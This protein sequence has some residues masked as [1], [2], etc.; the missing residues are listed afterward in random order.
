VIS[1]RAPATVRSPFRGGPPTDAH[2]AALEQL[3]DPGARE[4]ERSGEP[5]V[6]PHPGGIRRNLEAPARGAHS[7]S[8]SAT[9]LRGLEPLGRLLSQEAVRDAGED[10]VG[11]GVDREQRRGVG[12]QHLLPELVRRPGIEGRPAGEHLVEDDAQGVE[13][14]AGVETFTEDLLRRHVAEGTDQPARRR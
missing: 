8:A 14:G 7:D 1:T 6:H 12:L 5:H 4:G 9:S 10:G 11:A 13:V 3:L 2:G